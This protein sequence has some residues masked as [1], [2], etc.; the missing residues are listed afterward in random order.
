MC[1]GSASASPFGR[2]NENAAET[3]ALWKAL[4]GSPPFDQL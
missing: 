2:P 3:A 1:T 4:D